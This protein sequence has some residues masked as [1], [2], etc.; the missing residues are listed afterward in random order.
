MKI[1]LASFGL[2]ILSMPAFATDPLYTLVQGSAW[3]IKQANGEA[4]RSLDKICK[5]EVCYPLGPVSSVYLSIEHADALRLVDFKHLS[6]LASVKATGDRL[7]L[8]SKLGAQIYAVAHRESVR[9]VF[10][11]DD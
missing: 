9:E 11:F 2:L 10:Q 1:T 8:P 6:Q 7:E 5:G 4:I 3:N